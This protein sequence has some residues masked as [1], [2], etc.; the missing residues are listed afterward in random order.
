MPTY[1]FNS[2][3]VYKLCICII[4]VNAKFDRFSYCRLLFSTPDYHLQ[5]FV[6]MDITISDPNV[7]RPQYLK[8]RLSRKE[9]YSTSG[10]WLCV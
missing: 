5:L 9:K 7:S 10:L 3:Q 8:S 6:Y 4:I 1:P 2:L